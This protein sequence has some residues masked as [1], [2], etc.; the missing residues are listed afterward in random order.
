MARVS[1][2]RLPV[3]HA[4][5]VLRSAFGAIRLPLRGACS[6]TFDEFL[7]KL[8][9]VGFRRVHQWATLAVSTRRTT[10]STKPATLPTPANSA[11]F[12]SP[13][14]SVARGAE[15]RNEI[16]THEQEADATTRLHALLHL[17]EALRMARHDVAQQRRS[18]STQT[19]A[20]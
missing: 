9:A 6:T 11:R 3:A 2:R 4:F 17:R 19:V 13:S 20:D 7:E 18:T 16:L 5:S 10:I 14:A 8:L 1:L 15:V 12:E